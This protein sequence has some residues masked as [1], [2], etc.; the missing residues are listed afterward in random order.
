MCTLYYIIL[1]QGEAGADPGMLKR[2]VC[3]G[4]GHLGAQLYIL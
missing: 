2:C 3:E 4:G 1:Q